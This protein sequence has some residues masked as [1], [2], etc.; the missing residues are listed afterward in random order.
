M[1]IKG[2]DGDSIEIKE[3]DSISIEVIVEEWGSD[4]ISLYI[5]K[6][7]IHKIIEV[8]KELKEVER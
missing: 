7:K 6:D 2:Y 4:P 5:G 8:L 3:W 1:K